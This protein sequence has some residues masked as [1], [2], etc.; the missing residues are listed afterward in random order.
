M[1]VKA[2]PP[3]FDL[4]KQENKTF[5][6]RK[7]LAA[8]L[9]DLDVGNLWDWTN[10]PEKEVQY[11][12]GRI[13]AAAV[14]LPIE[15]GLRVVL[16]RYHHG[17]VLGH[18]QKDRYLFSFP[19]LKEIAA[20]AFA[21]DQGVPAVEILGAVQER[22]GLFNRIYL[23]T[24]H[25]PEGS[26]L[27]EFFRKQYERV[28]WRE[29]HQIIEETGKLIR[30]MHNEGL[31]HSDL[32]LKNIYMSQQNGTKQFYLLDF[33][34]A[35]VVPNL[36]KEMRLKN[37][38]RLERYL[39]K[40]FS[41]TSIFTASDRIRFLRAYFGSNQEAR[42][43][44]E[45]HIKQ[46]QRHVKTHQLLWWKKVGDPHWWSYICIRG[47]V[48]VLNLVPEQFSYSCFVLISK[49]A[50][51][52]VPKLR[53][54]IMNNLNLVYKETMSPEDKERLAK[55]IAKHLAFSFAEFTRSFS[56]SRKD[57]LKAREKYEFIGKENVEEGLRR[58]KGILFLVSHL[59]NWERLNLV[60]SWFD[61][62][63]YALAKQIKNKWFDQWV[64]DIRSRLGI[65]VL[66]A[67][68]MN[69]EILRV[70]KE[71]NTVA[72]LI[73]QNPGAGRGEMIP[74]MG[75]PAPTNTAPAFFALKSGATV[76]PAFCLRK[77]PGVFK[78]IIDPP[79]ELIQKETFRE[80]LTANTELFAKN[81]EE[82]VRKDPEQWFWV[83]NRWK[84]KTK[85]VK[86]DSKET[87]HPERSEG[88]S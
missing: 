26:D 33:D 29:K 38:L 59:G 23:I 53:R 2:I 36:S 6:L 46:F 45:R 64:L 13:P 4:I 55:N 61:F 85:K 82:Y 28:N 68:R 66:K 14:T 1:H 75:V 20:C 41:E 51:R 9:L 49:I 37:L 22:V 34:K 25:L 31:F 54:R 84:V 65:N 50:Y 43:F 74:F 77:S 67:N 24:K 70:L 57:L 79:V 21:H 27:G 88:S 10:D 73:D 40:Y 63:S 12:K 17:G 71:N 5:I 81:L 47:M 80:S 8:Q 76:L 86:N 62:K 48:A 56:M 58:G 60:E 18:F 39:A 83:H 52:I 3:E 32:H 72:V 35:H 16:R 19:P 30:K 78:F 11:Y 44:V 15:G 7:D 69:R 87:R 42:E